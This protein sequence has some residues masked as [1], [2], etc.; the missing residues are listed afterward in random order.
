MEAKVK[1]YE[2]GKVKSSKSFPS[3]KMAK[4]Y[5]VGAKSKM[6]TRQKVAKRAYWSVLKKTSKGWKSAR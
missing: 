1:Y 5:V 3:V 4:A 2:N 6:T